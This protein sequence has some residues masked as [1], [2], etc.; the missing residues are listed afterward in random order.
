MPLYLVRWPTLAASLVRAQDEDELLDIHDEAAD[1][2]GCTYEVYRGP[3]WIDFEVPFGVCD[4]TPEGTVP[5]DPSDFVVEPTP[6]FD[7]AV[8]FDILTVRTPVTDAA[9]EMRDEVLR[10]AFPEL[11]EFI[12]GIDYGEEGEVEDSDA[13]KAELQHALREELWPLIEYIGAR[14]EVA[15]RDDVEAT[16]MQQAGVTVMLPAMRRALAEMLKAMPAR[17]AD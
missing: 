12:D 10:G 17:K 3:V 2:G 1:P 5:T 7:G 16:M 13:A 11:A 15:A 6:D 14:S 4:R 9:G 8:D